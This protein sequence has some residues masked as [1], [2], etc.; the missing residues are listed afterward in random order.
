VSSDVKIDKIK[1]HLWSAVQEG[2]MRA[3][4]LEVYGHS[5]TERMLPGLKLSGDEV[6][7]LVELDAEMAMDASCEQPNSS[8]CQHGTPPSGALQF[9]Q[10]ETNAMSFHVLG[11][12]FAGLFHLFER[13]V[14]MVLDQLAHRFGGGVWGAKGRPT[15]PQL[16]DLRKALA[17]IGYRL[18]GERSIKLDRLQLIAN[19]VKHGGGTS[20]GKLARSHPDLLWGWQ[21]GSPATT[22]M[23]GLTPELFKEFVV[24]L[25]L[26]WREFP[27]A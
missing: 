23:L 27:H 18:I 7:K 17:R 13:Q 1:P 3:R 15:D 8:W 4:F 26:F 22:D 6:L 20:L 5:V 21:P 19:V 2:E 14:V 16:P 10:M 9:A 25:A 24:A 11:L 12:A